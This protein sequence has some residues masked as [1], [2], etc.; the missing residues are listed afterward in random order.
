MR[1]L[2]KIRHENKIQQPY[3]LFPFGNL[4]YFTLN[5]KILSISADWETEQKERHQVIRLTKMVNKEPSHFPTIL[6]QILFPV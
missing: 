3:P 4:S 6:I 5:H 2:I 1:V